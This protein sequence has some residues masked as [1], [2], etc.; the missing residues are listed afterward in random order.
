MKTYGT[1]FQSPALLVAA[2]A[3]AGPCAANQGVEYVHLEPLAIDCSP[4]NPLPCQFPAGTPATESN[5]IYVTQT[6]DGAGDL[7]FSSISTNMPGSDFVWLGTKYQ[8]RCKTSY[9]LRAIFLKTG[10]EHLSGEGPFEVED[11]GTDCQFLQDEPHNPK[12]RTVPWRHRPFAVPL[13]KVLSDL[14][15][16]E[17]DLFAEGEAIIAEKVAAGF[18]EASARAMTDQ[19]VRDFPVAVDVSCG[20]VFWST[21]FADGDSAEMP[22]MIRYVGYGE[23]AG[24]E[25]DDPAP[26]SRDQIDPLFVDETSVTQAELFAIPD[27]NGCGL[28]LSAVFTSNAPTTIK[29]RLVD[30]L[31]VK[32]QL[33]HVPVNHTLTAY[34][35]HWIDLSDVVLESSDL[36]LV[37]SSDSDGPLGY[38]TEDTD[39][40]Q[41][42][43]QVEVLLPHH[44]MSNLA[45]YN[46]PACSPDSEI[47]QFRD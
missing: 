2:L 45:S 37:A 4:G 27:E 34:V 25:L 8:A 33:F 15:L 32:S 23:T 44:K 3:L 14:G 1:T 22:L 36:G 20:H 7:H 30:D 42:Y 16:T 41:G 10:H 40:S 39:R 18:S 5:V 13:A 38:T 9:R 46:L 28:S 29:Y 17:A 11:C 26:A 19:R 31:G 24:L 12:N 35:N 21:E 47:P 43:Y 6:S